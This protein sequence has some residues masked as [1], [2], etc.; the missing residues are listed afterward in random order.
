MKAT[1]GPHVPE[2]ILERYALGQIPDEDSVG[3]E[4]HLLV[5]EDCQDRLQTTDEF[6]LAMRQAAMKMVNQPRSRFERFTAMLAGF[7]RGW[8]PVYAAGFAVAAL[9]VVIVSTMRPPDRLGEPQLVALRS[10]RGED[11]AG[12]SRALAGKPLVLRLDL[13]GI[14][15]L[16]AYRV[17][18]VN[19]RGDRVWDSMARPEGNTLATPVGTALKAGRHWVRLYAQLLRQ[20]LLRE[21]GLTVE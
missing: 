15:A 13:T 3:V 21:Y 10:I 8:L 12:I 16:D 6:V 17:E 5:C 19:A 11:P 9:A 4:E 1:F 14:E 18:I 7:R 2:D 20:Q